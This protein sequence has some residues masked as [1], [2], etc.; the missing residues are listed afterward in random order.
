MSTWKLVYRIFRR[1][2]FL[3]FFLTG[4][5]AVTACS[6]PTQA[7]N[8]KGALAQSQLES[9]RL[10]EA[11][12][13]IAAAIEE[14]DDIPE[15]HLL[16]ARIEMQANSRPT[17]FSAYAA[18]L[19]LD[20]TSMEALTGVAQ[21]G[22]QLGYVSDSAEATDRIIDLD[23][24]QPI[25]LLLKGL[26]NMIKRRY[27][28][29]VGNADAILAMNPASEDASI[30]KA[31]ALA[32]MSRPDEAYAVVEKFRKGGGNTQSVALTL[33]ELYRVRADGASMV[34]E[35]ER[36]RALAPD[37]ASYDIDE[38]DTL[39][40]LGDTARARAI[41]QQRLLD[42]KVDEKTAGAIARLLS[43]YDPEPLAP[44]KLA[45]FAKKAGIPARKALA[46]LYLDRN[47]PTRARAVLAGAPAVDDIVALQALAAVAQG[48]LDGSLAQAD[49][50]LSK[51]KTH[52]DALV[53]KAQVLL[54]KRRTGDAIAASTLASTTCPQ[55]TNGF[56]T[57]ARAQEASGNAAG[58]MIAFRDGFDR[59]DQDPLI[60]RSYVAWLERHS[61]GTRAVSIASRL[62]KNAPALLSAW[63]LYG[64]VCARNPS[65]DCN[66]AA[67]QGLAD[68]RTRFGVDPRTDERPPTGLFGRLS[69]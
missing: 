43:E 63:K 15:L 23:P 13:T 22:L 4:V 33:L 55:S 7:A 34:G 1:I 51:D 54:A 35:L 14:R 64:E 9:G 41:L 58:A 47:D 37:N 62:T 8:E 49:A 36:I 17:A 6:D 21:L 19:A 29:A 11:R 50:I 59:N 68:A 24:T 32:V 27:A 16:H 53:V 69:S 65:A 48:S 57:L 66:G 20:S 26:H 38:A 10:A 2:V 42:P 28:D 30:L 18:A 44:A 60:V 56:L 52:C 46:R 25:G 45:E 31:R 39:Y 12:K 3:A 61:Q 5:L 40:K 67:E